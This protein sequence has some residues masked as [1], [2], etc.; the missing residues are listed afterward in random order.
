MSTAAIARREKPATRIALFG[1]DA[2]S[3]AVLS[4]CFGQFGVET[5][6]LPAVPPAGFAADYSAAVV[7]LNAQGEAT[8][9]EVRKASHSLVVY[10]ICGSIREALPYSKWGV[11]AVFYSPLVQREALQIVRS[12]HLLLMKELRRYVRVPLVC[13]VML[14]TGTQKLEAS[15][16][17]IS[18]GG[19]MLTTKAALTVPQAV[20]ATFC[21][22]GASPTSVRS[23][24][25]WTRNDEA[26]AAIRFDPG[27]TRRSAVRDWIDEYLG[28]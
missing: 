21:L 28:A 16:M 1:V 7:P 27:D 4:D 11:N 14:E 20:L 12:T 5:R 10:G 22:P 6:V 26:T 19:M 15:S 17:E 3:A 13:P 25:C 8:L 2:A 23:V 9:R 18:A 24:V